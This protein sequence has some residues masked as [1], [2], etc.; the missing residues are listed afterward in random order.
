MKVIY[1]LFLITN[2]LTFFDHTFKWIFRK[3]VWQQPYGN[4]HSNH[5]CCRKTIRFDCY[6]LSLIN[7]SNTYN[8]PYINDYSE[9]KYLCKILHKNIQPRRL[10]YWNVSCII[11]CNWQN[12]LRVNNSNTPMRIYLSY[13]TLVLQIVYKNKHTRN[14]Q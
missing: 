10:L 6:D 1:F 9:H 5:L 3:K 8:H 12:A 11:Q 13:D 2:V 7:V 14:K 4:K